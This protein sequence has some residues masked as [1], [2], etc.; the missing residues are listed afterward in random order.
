MPIRRSQ[1]L[2]GPEGV[3]MDAEERGLLACRAASDRKALD[4]AVL[5]LR[6]ISSITDLFLVC[7]GQN[8]RQMRAIAE[9][10]DNRLSERGVEPL[11]REG[12]GEGCWLLLDYDDLVIHIFS[13]DARLFYD[14]E[15]LWTQAPRLTR[16]A[17]EPI[18]APPAAG[19][20]SPAAA[21]AEGVP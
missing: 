4:I 1:K 20:P 11:S 5:D 19:K 17:G 15:R 7:S 21:R 6:E 16:L 8:P 12:T 13:E 9:E 10:I 18:P 3:M 14:L 2:P